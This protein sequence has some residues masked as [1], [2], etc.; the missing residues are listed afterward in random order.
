MLIDPAAMVAPRQ[1]QPRRRGLVLGAVDGGGAVGMVTRDPVCGT[2]RR[3]GEDCN[4]Q[5]RQ[6]VTGAGGRLAR[7]LDEMQ[8]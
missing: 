4:A 1:R 3:G 8:E 7:E 5:H 2:L 6:I